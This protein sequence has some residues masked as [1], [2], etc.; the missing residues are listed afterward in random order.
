MEGEGDGR[1]P[2]SLS[3]FFFGYVLRAPDMIPIIKV[4]G[5]PPSRPLGPPWALASRFFNIWRP[6]ELF[7]HYLN[8][9][10]YPQ[11]LLARA[12]QVLILALPNTSIAQRQASLYLPYIIP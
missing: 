7:S 8:K 9:F 11:A 4:P 10:F 5:G 12:A 3:S 6:F 2:A 1:E